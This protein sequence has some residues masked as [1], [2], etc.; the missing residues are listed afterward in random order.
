[1]NMKPD[2]RIFDLATWKEFSTI[3]VGS[4]ADGMGWAGD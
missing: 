3:N 1:M 4:K 2:I